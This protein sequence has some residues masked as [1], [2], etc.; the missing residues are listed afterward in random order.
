MTWSASL[1]P[2]TT[3]PMKSFPQGLYALTSE[4]HFKI[5]LFAIPFRNDEMIVTI[6]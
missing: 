6:N 1:S 3:E 2:S 4:D 5:Q